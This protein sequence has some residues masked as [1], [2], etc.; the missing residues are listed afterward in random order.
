MS[1]TVLN[2]TFLLCCAVLAV[3]PC[4]FVI[5][6]VYQDGLIGRIG[7][8]GISF[9]AATYVMAWFDYE[10]WPDFP[11]EADL[12]EVMMFGFAAIFLV[13]HLFRFHSRVVR[14]ASRPLESR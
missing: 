4:Y 13:W 5:H 3:V 12:Q 8:L 11:F 10:E 9:T 6:K 2:A 1:Q 14:S 7:L